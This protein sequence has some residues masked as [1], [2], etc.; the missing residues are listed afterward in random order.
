MKR[1]SLVFGTHNTQPVGEL[2]SVYERA[3]E[4]AYKP[5]LT[6]L[7]RYPELHAVLHYSGVLLEWFERN[8][9]VDS[10]RR[11]RA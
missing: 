2:E 9:P 5:F 3:Y 11:S 8:H 4:R 1:V 6:V 10:W 7:N